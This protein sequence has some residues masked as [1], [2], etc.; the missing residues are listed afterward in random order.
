MG[1][2]WK[3]PISYSKKRMIINV[4]KEKLYKRNAK[5]SEANLVINND[6]LIQTKFIEQI[7]NIP[8][9][10]K[11]D[12]VCYNS[13]H[14]IL[15]HDDPKVIAYYL[16]QFYPFPENDKWWG[17][18]TTEWNNVSKAIPQFVGHYQP[19]LPGEL[20]YY[21]LRLKE[22]ME[23]QIELAKN[24]GIYGFCFY[25]YWFNGKR[26]LDKPLDMFL[27]NSMKFNYCLCWVNE[28]WT[29]R[30]DGT[31]SDILIENG[32]TEESYMKFINSILPYISD[33]RYI[34]IE[35]KP[36]IIIYR[37]S[38]VPNAKK[39]IKYWR[40]YILNKTGSD[41]YIIGIIEGYFNKDIFE[42]GYDAAAEFQPGSISINL[43]EINSKLDFIRK[44]F[45]G[46]VYDYNEIINKNLLYYN[47]NNLKIYKAVMPMWDNTARKNNCGAIFHNSTPEIYE[48]WLSDAIKYTN[49]NKKLEDNLVFI[50][51]WNE[52]GEGAYLEPDRRYG[53][54]YLEK[55]KQAILSNRKN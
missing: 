45:K 2:Y 38:N 12:Y 48:N 37:P 27:N 49:N 52:W 9:N 50:N 6:K 43:N 36:V 20:G 31:N 32:K 55:T 44:D 46:K 51:A 13:E 16:P 40:E 53:Y 7:L 8:V 14:L 21:D 34:K 15:K 39:I 28:N 4:V 26:L 41:I 17:K 30:F 35:N 42:Q 5:Q 25:Y 29:R 18:G 23:R 3:I 11:N 33:D 19:R 47:Y 1:L 10:N 24:Y 22:N 54:A